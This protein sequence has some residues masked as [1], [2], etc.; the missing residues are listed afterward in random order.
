M[1]PDFTSLKVKRDQV[2]EFIENQ[3]FPFHLV[4]YQVCE[5]GCAMGGLFKP[6]IPVSLSNIRSVKRDV[7]WWAHSSQ[8]FPCHFVITINEKA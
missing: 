8:S 3:S 5:T 1:A 7:Q 4:K 2:R 6:I